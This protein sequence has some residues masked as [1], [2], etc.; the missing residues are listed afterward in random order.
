MRSSSDTDYLLPQLRGLGQDVFL[1]AHIYE[2]D[3][4]HRERGENEQRAE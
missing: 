1:D 3:N 2:Q 4:D